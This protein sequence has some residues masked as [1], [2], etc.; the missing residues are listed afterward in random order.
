MI[1]IAGFLKV[2]LFAIFDSN[3]S[4]N[5]GSNNKFDTIAKS[6]V[7]ETSPPRAI[8]PPKLDTVN[9]KKPKKRTIEV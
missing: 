1:T 6:K 9:T 4:N 8:V 2:F 7:T 5:E 3:E